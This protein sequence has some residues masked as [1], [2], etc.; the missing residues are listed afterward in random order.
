MRDY[1]S[2]Q[3]IR[4]YLETFSAAD[5]RSTSQVGCRRQSRAGVNR[6][7]P[8]T[9][10]T[11]DEAPL[12][13]ILKKPQPCVSNHQRSSWA[14]AALQ[15]QRRHDQCPCHRSLRRLATLTAPTR[16]SAGRCS[17][18][19]LPA[20]GNLSTM[21]SAAIKMGLSPKGKPSKYAGSLPSFD[22]L[23]HTLK[24]RLAG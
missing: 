14:T 13:P 8:A 7:R 19:T 5:Q 3:S 10:S 1:K 9:T 15:G 21:V 23:S 17:A 4:D 22:C 12:S 6:L 18:M 24:R 16:S 20:S 11:S 2:P